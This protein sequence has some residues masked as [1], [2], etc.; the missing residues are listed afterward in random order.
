MR[1]AASARKGSNSRR[2]IL[3]M[4]PPR[5]IV[6]NLGLTGLRGVYPSHRPEASFRFLL[7]SSSDWGGGSGGVGYLRTKPPGG[8]IRLTKKPPPPY[9]KTCSLPRPHPQ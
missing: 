4:I 1:L 3:R 7:V 2:G 8:G 9:G 6:D 5:R